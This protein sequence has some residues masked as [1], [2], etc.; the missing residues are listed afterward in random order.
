MSE[1][2]KKLK[3]QRGMSGVLEE[4]KPYLVLFTVIVVV[5]MSILV[6][7]L[8]LNMPVVS[9]CIL[10]LLEAA[11]AACLQQVPIWLHAVVV[12]AE[13]LLGVLCGKALL[14]VICTVVYLTGIFALKLLRE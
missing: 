1:L 8:A 7:I 9:V 3:E 10:I 14:M 2:K 4:N 11:I 5:L 12:I 6:S 13:I